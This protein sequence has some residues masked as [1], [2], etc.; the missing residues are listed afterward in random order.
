MVISKFIKYIREC[1]FEYLL[2][3]IICSRAPDVWWAIG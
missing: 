1:G 3:N 2:Y